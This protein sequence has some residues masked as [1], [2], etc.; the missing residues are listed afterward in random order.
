MIKSLEKEEV[1]ASPTG[2]YLKHGHTSN[3]V[4]PHT[5]EL[6]YKRLLIQLKPDG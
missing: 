5:L 6:I 3:R 4:C 1:S 2:M